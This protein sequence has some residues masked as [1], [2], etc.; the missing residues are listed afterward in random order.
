[1]TKGLPAV[2]TEVVSGALMGFPLGLEPTG[3]WVQAEARPRTDAATR[4]AIEKC[5][6]LGIAVMRLD[7]IRCDYMIR[8]RKDCSI[9]IIKE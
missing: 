9:D 8:I 6:L 3:F 4:A 5:I 7:A 2:T 1:M